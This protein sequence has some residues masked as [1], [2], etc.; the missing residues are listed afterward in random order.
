MSAFARQLL[1]EWKCL[2]LPAAG[3]RIIIAVSGGADSTALLLALDEL[4]QTRRL[5]L[6]LT[7]AHLN[8]G[9]RG[10][11]SEQDALWVAELSERLG[12]EFT[13]GKI[14]VRARAAD[15]VD[16][17][18]QAARRARYEFLTDAAARCEAVAVLTAHTMDDQAETLLLRLMRGSGAD[19]LGSMEPV[20]S[21][22]KE[23][24]VL[25]ARP[26]LRWARRVE[27]EGYCRELGVA[28]RV[29]AMNDDESLARVRVRKQLLPLMRTFNG[30]ITEALSR[31]AA[32]LRDDA[33]ALRLEAEKLLEE[34]SDAATSGRLALRVNVL[35]GAHVSVRRRALRLW[36]ARRRGDT[37]R[38][39]LVHL[40][41]VEKLL[42][43]ERGGRVADLP[44]G[45]FIERKRGLICFQ[46]EKVEKGSRGV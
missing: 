4:V 13:L 5:S 46:A 45:S 30:R 40:L 7:V 22:D 34:A 21:F 43:G 8:H 17:L 27:T 12:Y 42:F 1:M 15:V 25:L 19:G 38:L 37:R 23:N 16:N 44:G 11:D 3:E 2:G 14:D 31:T 28:F 10:T 36:I 18:E 6:T 35:A 32:L 41:A 29:D 20:R 9:L 33:T 39:E 26:L 24:A